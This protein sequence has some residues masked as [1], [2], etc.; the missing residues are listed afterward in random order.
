MRRGLLISP[1][2]PY[3][4]EAELGS[5]FPFALGL[6]R[7]PDAKYRVS[8]RAILDRDQP[9]HDL[10]VVVVLAVESLPFLL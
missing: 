4:H 9:D 7:L 3:R 8:R 10:R 2:K 6:C 1:H 5:V